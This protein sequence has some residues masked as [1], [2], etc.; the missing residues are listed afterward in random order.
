MDIVSIAIICHNVNRAYCQALGDASQPTWADAP[1]W[2][3]ES[4]ILGV[5]LH[6]T[7]PE[8]GPEA[9]HVSWLAAKVADGWKYGPVKNAEKKEHPCC[10]TY[11]QLPV[12]QQAKDFIFCEIVHQLAHL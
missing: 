2:Q 8:D 7:H 3:R 1:Q 9:S 11:N 5:E 6:M 10:V 4:A 12:A